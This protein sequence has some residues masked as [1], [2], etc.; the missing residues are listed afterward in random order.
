MEQG[1]RVRWPVLVVVLA[2]AAAGY[3][4]WQRYESSGPAGRPGGGKGETAASQKI[5]VT[6]AEAQRAD[7]PVYLRGLGTVSAFKTVTV[8]SRVDGAITKVLFKQGQLI[9]EGD[10]LVE[11]DRRPYQAVLDQAVAKK[12][13]DE[14][15]LK[16]NQIILERYRSLVEKSFESRQNFDTQQALVDQLKAQI[17]GDQATIDSARVNLDY[18]TISSPI[19]GRVGFRLIDPGNIVHAADA[20]GI[21]TITQLQP[22]AVEFTAPQDRLQ[23]IAK[24]YDGGR[25]PVDAIASDGTR[26]LAQGRLIAIN[27]T[28]DIASGTIGLKA[29]FANQDNALWPGLSVNTRMQIDTLKQVIVIPENGVM[30][31]PSGLFAYVI[32]DDGKVSARP[33]E[34]DASDDERAV[35]RTGLDAGQKIVIAGQSRLQE[36]AAVDARPSSAVAAPPAAPNMSAQEASSA[37]RRAD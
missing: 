9:R 18:T 34:V 8:K 2:V 32:G 15:N 26:T 21:V 6:Y 12:A 14:A 36:G 10:P 11:I 13:Q 23:E 30:H 4:G 5:P 37:A 28:V 1:T 22:I 7:Y 31:G 29:R 16:N 17:Q 19:T 33:I 24:A 25:V 35:V 3:L 20:N 27:N